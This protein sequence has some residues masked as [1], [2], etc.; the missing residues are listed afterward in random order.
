VAC[1]SKKKEITREQEMERERER[2]RLVR[3]SFFNILKQL[4]DSNTSLQNRDIRYKA[5]KNRSTQKG[6]ENW[7][8]FL[9]KL[10]QTPSPPF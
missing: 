7:L 9:P 1:H 8:Q 10:E 4:I 6:Q 3:S 5:F 2:E